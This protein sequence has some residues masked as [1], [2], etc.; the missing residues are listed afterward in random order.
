MMSYENAFRAIKTAINSKAFQAFYDNAAVIGNFK[1]GV[2]SDVE[3]RL[4]ATETDFVLMSK[5]S[6]EHHKS[7]HPEITL[8]DY[9]K[10]PEIIAK[11][12]IYE[13]QERRYILLKIE[14]K[15][16]RAAMKVTKSKTEVYLLSLIAQSNK[17]ADIE[18]R[19]KFKQLR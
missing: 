13:T 2:L 19:N 4:L 15:T 5:E 6:L 9:K 10:L 3:K 1:V 16:Y 18:I 8:D 14:E 11:G 7:K 17:K 12:E